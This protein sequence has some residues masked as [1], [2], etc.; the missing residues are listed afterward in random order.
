MDDWKNRLHSIIEY[1]DVSDIFY[2]D[3]TSLFFQ[4]MP[5]RSLLID[6]NDCRGGKRSKD[7]YT[8]MLCFS[9]LGIEKLKP[10]V[11]G[12]LISIDFIVQ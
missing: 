10:A 2:C 1:Y 9:M 3:E 7:R 8:V 5:D 11:I 6:R 4:L 12:N